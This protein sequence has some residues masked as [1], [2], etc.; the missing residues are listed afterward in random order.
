[1]LRSVI[2]RLLYKKL[3]YNPDRKIMKKNLLIALFAV[4]ALAPVAAQAARGYVGVNV[5]R[6][7]QKVTDDEFADYSSKDK[8]TAAK[9]YGGFQFTPIFGIEGGFADM[10]KATEDGS[11]DSARPRSLYVAATGTWHVKE[12]LALFGK[13]GAAAN[14]TKIESP[15]FGS[16]TESKATPMVGVGISYGFTPS[17][18]GVAEYENFGDVVKENGVKLN[19]AALTFGLRFKF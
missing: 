13:V 19:V 18:W 14:R 16:D 7:L 9:V 6:S 3:Q 4:A 8:G 1:M 15:G 5:G 10:G 11:D 17:V 2:Y 12:R